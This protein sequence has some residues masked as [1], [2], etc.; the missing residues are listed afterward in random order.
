VREWDAVSNDLLFPLQVLVWIRE[1]QGS[2][3]PGLGSQSARCPS[4]LALFHLQEQA[5]NRNAAPRAADG[6]EAAIASWLD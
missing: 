6:E 2:P 5:P 1:D 3:T 4:F